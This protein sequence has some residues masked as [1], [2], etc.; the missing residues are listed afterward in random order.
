[1]SGDKGLPGPDFDEYNAAL[2]SK[3]AAEEI[4]GFVLLAIGE[5]VIVPKSLLANGIPKGAE[6]RIDEH[7]EDETFVFSVEVDRE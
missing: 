6:I 5:P 2:K 7:V 3:Q 4:L 1:M